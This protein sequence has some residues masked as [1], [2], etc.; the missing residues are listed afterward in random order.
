MPKR[1]LN[2]RTL[3][4]LKPA[5]VNRRYEIMDA[6]VPGLAIRITDKG[7][8]S[9]VLV[10]R[11]P[12][13][14]NP[15]RRSLGEYGAL[16]LEGARSKARKWI[17]LLHRGIDPRDEVERQQLAEQRKRAN[18]FAAVAEDFIRDKLPGE[19]KGREVERNIRNE[20]VAVWGKRAIAEITDLD[21]LAVIKAKKATAPV[22]ARNLLGVA[23][24]LFS[25]AVDQRCYGLSGSPCVQIK[26]LAIVGERTTSNRV[27]DDDEI[28]ALW[29]AAQR[30]G[31][32]Y[33]HVYQ[34][35]LLTGLRL[36]EVADASGPEF[37]P[38]EGIWTI[39][40]ERMKGKNSRARPHAV[41]L[42]PD[43]VA[44]LDALPKFNRGKFLFSSTFGEKAIWMTDRVKVRLDKRMARTLRA[45]ARKRGEEP[46]ELKPWTNH[47]IRRS[48]RTRL[49]RLK[50]SEEAREAVLA[51]VRPG[52]KGVYDAH[53]YL[54]EKREALELWAARLRSIVQPP[55][56][57][58]TD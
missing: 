11:F 57:P 8:K 36:N 55:P 28:F 20:F 24:R 2:D 9:F 45:L 42:I 40:A 23:K 56:A 7:T 5:K 22:Q 48:V 29:R 52:I 47:D 35:L 15:T 39:P 10:A 37:N 58:R 54:A 53:D 1:A 30:M 46:P 19:R 50:I 26:P 27:L 33:G 32:P 44:I 13:S 49:S 4:A 41:P 17:E 12:G 38:R 16:S 18:A 14:N 21:V 3:R 34:L 6:V 43:I 31:Y 25:W 51:H